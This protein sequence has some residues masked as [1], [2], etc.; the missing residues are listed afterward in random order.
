MLGGVK[1]DD[2]A[3]SGQPSRISQGSVI[4]DAC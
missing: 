1:C 3:M 4:P 2:L